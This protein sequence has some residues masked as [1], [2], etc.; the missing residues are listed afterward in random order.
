[1]RS[2]THLEDAVYQERIAKESSRQYQSE[3]RVKRDLLFSIQMARARS[4]VE[5]EPSFALSMLHDYQICPI[6]ERRPSWNFIVRNAHSNLLTMPGHREAVTD[7]NYSPDGRHIASVGED[8]FVRIREASTGKLVAT[9]GKRPYPI[10]GV[11]FS[12]D[13]A[14]LITA[15]GSI[16]SR[17]GENHLVGYQESTTKI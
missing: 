12:L 1:M 9:F 13:G 6:N 3:L 16:S 5:L 14:T 2:E 4:V 8:G 11:V 7:L 10:H 17:K 15:G